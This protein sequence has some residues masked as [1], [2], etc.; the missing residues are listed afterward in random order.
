LRAKEPRFHKVEKSETGQIPPNTN[1]NNQ[2]ER[3]LAMSGN[4]D[5]YRCIPP[6]VRNLR[7]SEVRGHYR[8]LFHNHLRD[9]LQTLVEEVVEEQYRIDG[10]GTS[11]TWIASGIEQPFVTSAIHPCDP[12]CLRSKCDRVF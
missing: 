4:D 11:I 8:K 1:G 12:R 7:R 6:I 9:W 10:A 2:P 5:R 3:N